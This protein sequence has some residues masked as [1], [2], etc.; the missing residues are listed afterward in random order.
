MELR[1]FAPEPRVL[2][3]DFDAVATRREHA[4]CGEAAES[5]TDDADASLIHDAGYSLPEFACGGD[6]LAQAGEVLAPGCAMGEAD[7]AL[8]ERGVVRA[9]GLVLARGVAAADDG[10]AGCRHLEETFG[11]AG[12][13]E[14]AA[15]SAGEVQAR[16][17]G[18]NDDVVNEDRA[19]AQV[20]GKCAGF[21]LFAEDDGG[22]GV[23]ACGAGGEESLEVRNSDH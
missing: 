9:G 6:E 15:A 16:G 10:R 2:F 19:G 14:A 12:G 18:R 20:W 11:T 17:G 8:E 1:G 7:H 22:E 21:G 5:R 3:E 4:R 23:G 13:T